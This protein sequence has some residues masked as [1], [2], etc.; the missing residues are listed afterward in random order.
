MRETDDRAGP[1]NPV[2]LREANAAPAVR[3]LELAA[4]CRR[5]SL[6]AFEQLYREH[7]ARMK[8]IAFNLLG[9][10]SDAEDAVQEVFLKAYRGIGGFKGQS[11]FSTWIYRILVNCCYDLGRRKSR[12][13]EASEPEPDAE[14]EL[15]AWD[16]VAG[17]VA[18]HPLRLALE[19]CLKRL[20]PKHRQVFVLFEIEGFKHSEIAEMLEISETLSKNRVYEAKQQLRQWLSSEKR[21]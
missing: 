9:N 20:S 13:Q 21:S 17:P 7:G 4:A 1:A 2:K 16:T 19:S 6:E 3:D 10:P 14:R 11:A 12:R 18:D 5:G 15:E 8:S